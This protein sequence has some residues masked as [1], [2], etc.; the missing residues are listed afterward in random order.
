MPMA[1]KTKSTP[2]PNRR[3]TLVETAL[4]LFL[5][6]GFQGVG[7]DRI[8]GEAGVAKMTL[9]KHF[10]SKDALVV[11]ALERRD[12]RYREWIAEAVADA[13]PH[14]GAGGL[15]AYLGAVERWCDTPEFRGCLFVNAAA[16]YADP[17]HPVR[18]AVA[19]HK[20]AMHAYVRELAAAAGA[21]DPDGLAVQTRLL[22]EGAVIA[23]QTTGSAE[24]F[25][26]AQMAL[27]RLLAAG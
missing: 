7:I 21:D 23:K 17:G 13:G 6:H 5:A 16:E 20:A 10:R 1:E 12:R 15:L 25:R 19:A 27:V 2:R 9:Y 11:A 14:A 4:K 26:A 24:G 8:L 18:W 3:D 22:S